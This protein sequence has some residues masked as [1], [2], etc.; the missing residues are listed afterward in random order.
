[1]ANAPVRSLPGITVST[2]WL[3]SLG[4]IVNEEPVAWPD[5]VLGMG[6]ACVYIFVSKIHWARMLQ[7]VGKTILGEM[8]VKEVSPHFNLCN[9]RH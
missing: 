4:A 7:V 3:R 2:S 1:M 6:P 8:V 9:N 5:E